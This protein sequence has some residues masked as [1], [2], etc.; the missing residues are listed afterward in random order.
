M[1]YFKI[2]LRTTKS[3]SLG[4]LENDFRNGKEKRFGAYIPIPDSPSEK[5]LLRSENAARRG[6]DNGLL[7]LLPR[8][9]VWM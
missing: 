1:Y 5:P 4:R 9:K 2:V 6:H 3:I 8:G 7:T